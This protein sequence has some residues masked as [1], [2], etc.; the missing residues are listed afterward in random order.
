MENIRIKN[1]KN[2][3]LSIDL[4]IQKD[5]KEIVYI[6]HGLS[7]FKNQKHIQMFKDAFLEKNIGAVLI[8]ASNSFNESGGDYENITTTSHYNDLV[9]V[10]EWSKSQDW[11]K[12]PFYLAGHSLGGYSILKYAYDHPKQVKAMAPISSVVS[13]DLLNQVL[14]QDT[15]NK[16]K[17][18]GYIEEISSSRPGIIK[19]RKIDFYKDGKKHNILDKAL[20]ISTPTLLIIGEKDNTVLLKH[21]EILLKNLSGKKELHI[22]PEAG[23]NF[24][25][26]EDLKSIKS[27]ICGWLDRIE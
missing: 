9:D 17:E 10:V 1:R 13:V 20:E 16:W 21:Q 24:K 12:E 14:G 19:R 27:I 5:S 4:H 7:G 6:L 2:I 8:D 15:I 3:E 25:S 22:I 18:D 11:Y 26:D 23:H